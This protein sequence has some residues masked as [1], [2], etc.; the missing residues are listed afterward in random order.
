LR[1]V[2]PRR[3]RGRG[4]GGLNRPRAARIA[5]AA[6]LAIAGCGGSAKKPPPRPPAPVREPALAIGITEPNPN[7]FR[8][9][10]VDPVFAAARDQVVALHPAYY[11]LVIDWAHLQP[12][13]DQPPNLD[14]HEPGCMRDVGPCGAW[15]GVRDQLRALAARQREGGWQALVVI[16]GTP[17]WAAEPN[18]GCTRGT[19]GG[20]AAIRRDALPRYRALVAAVLAAARQAGADLR[21]WSPRNE[22]NHPYFGPQRS[23]CRP[24]APSQAAAD[25]APVAEALQAALAAAPG[26]QRLALGELAGVRSPTAQ[27]TSIGEFIAGLPKDLVCAADVWTQHAYIGGSDPAGLVSDALRARGCPGIP[28]IWITETGVGA[29]DSRLSIARGIQDGAEGCRL[30]H[31]QLAAW[32]RDPRVAAAFQYTAREDPL[33]PTG[34]VSANLA[35]ARPALAEWRAWGGRRRP[36]DPVPAATCPPGPA[37]TARAR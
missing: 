9:G 12:S 37:T 10:R 36:D 22:P 31:R 20:S 8:P 1:L 21:W 11:R 35:E 13:P 25:Y 3:G 28:P 6:L 27:A 26:D 4:L 15:G 23:A 33:F 17:A 24:D 14:L 18:T 16:T 34:L 5:L 7:L 2:V 19:S 29:A 32:W 30:L